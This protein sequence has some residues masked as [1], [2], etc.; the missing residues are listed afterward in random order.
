MLDAFLPATTKTNNTSAVWKSDNDE[1]SQAYYLNDY[2]SL[3]AIYFKVPS[4]TYILQL[5]PVVWEQIPIS[6]IGERVLY[7]NQFDKTTKHKIHW[8]FNGSNPSKERGKDISN[9]SKLYVKEGDSYYIRLLKTKNIESVECKL[10]N[11]TVPQNVKY[12]VGHLYDLETNTCLLYAH[13]YYGSHVWISYAS[14]F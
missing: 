10:N 6:S 2:V 3:T 4:P 5:E 1:V 9:D 7:C 11:G 12:P 13:S 14:T 8:R